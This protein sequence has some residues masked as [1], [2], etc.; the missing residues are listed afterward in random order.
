MVFMP[1]GCRLGSALSLVLDSGMTFD[2]RKFVIDE[3]ISG[4]FTMTLD[5]FAIDSAID[6]ESVVGQAAQ[7]TISRGSEERTWTGICRSI[8]LLKTQEDGLST[9][10]LVIVP[11]LWLL[12]QRTNRRIF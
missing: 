12:T 1:V 8:E 4:L 9:Y 11:V 10:Q 2:V 7:F 3:R 5:A 6:F